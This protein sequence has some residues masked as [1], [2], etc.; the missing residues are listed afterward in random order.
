MAGVQRD[1]KPASHT[2]HV[3]SHTHW[4]REWRYPYQ[5]FRMLLID[6][7]DNLIELM[8]KNPDYRHFLLDSQT[9]PLEDYLEIRPDRRAAL[10]KLVRDGRIHIGPWYC[11]PDTPPIS[12]ESIVRN[13]L[14]G[15]RITEEWGGKKHTGYS[16]FSFGQ[17]AQMPQ[18]YQGFGI[19]HIFFYR[20][21][22][23][24]VTPTEFTWEA[25]DGTQVLG[26]R[27]INPYGRANFYVHVY[28]PVV[29]NKKPFDWTYSW[30][31][32][33]T[34]FHPCDGES[35]RHDYLFLNPRHTK[36][37]H[38]ENLKEA[39]ENIKNDAVRDA[40]TE[41]LLYLDGMDQVNPQP[42]VP[43]IV[44]DANRAG[45]PDRYIHTSFHDY[46]QALKKSVKN[47]P[48][49][50][51]EF[52]HTMREGLWM[53]LFAATLCSRVYLKLANR[54][55]ENRLQQNAEPL[56]VFAQLLG[57]RYRRELLLHA[58][59]ML[60]ANQSHDSIAGCAVD[61]VHEDTEYR[62]RQVTQIAANVAR[63]AMGEV[64]SHIDL[65]AQSDSVIALAVYNPTNHSRTQVLRV[66]V[67]L[68]ESAGARWFGVLDGKREC[69]VQFINDAPFGPIVKSPYD[70]PVPFKARRVEALVEVPDVPPMGYR[71]LVIEPR[72]G[73][74][75]NHG[76]MCPA[77]GVMENEHLRVTVRS[78]GL[79]DILHKPTGAVHTG[80]HNFEDSSEVGDPWTHRQV[81]REEKVYGAGFPV[82]IRR[83]LDGP[84]AAAYEVTCCMRLPEAADDA[85]TE[86][87][88]RTVPFD[89]VSTF[90]LAHGARALAVRTVV[91][92][93]A[94][95]HKLRVLFPTGIAAAKRSFADSHYDTVERDIAV[96]DTSTWKEPAMTVYPHYLY[97]GVQ[98][99][100]RGFAVLARG[101]PEY[102]MI[103]DEP[104]TYALTLLRTY[105][106]PIIGADPEN[107]A[108]DPTQ[109]GGQCLR[110]MAFEYAI[111][112]YG[113]DYRDG[114]LQREAE[115][116]NVPM[117][118]A[119]LGKTQGGN[120]PMALSMLEVTPKQ[121]VLTA[122]KREER[123]GGGVVRIYNPGDT[124]VKGTVRFFRKPKSAA[125]VDL[126]E[127]R[128]RKLAVTGNGATLTVP[129]KKIVT[130]RFGF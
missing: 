96:P 52:R 65:S 70:F 73:P 64:V 124:A 4:D 62:Y 9:V 78:D 30:E 95:D 14:V 128:P 83:V 34:P 90:T 50:R 123:G 94:R 107:V 45:A 100:G 119:Q 91:N 92:N 57:H 41:H 3:V 49:I 20:G 66:F 46:V 61:A 116:F 118:A 58:W 86:R 12:G 120:L 48:V 8:T 32:G 22:N 113:G 54:E 75:V 53:N 82:E 18:I 33:Q 37:Y 121:L 47:L 127:K 117:R 125:E 31:E 60:L 2:M 63:Y 28:R 103:D 6:M 26:M 129:P 115:F 51:G 43:R 17:S 68:P 13:L 38:P 77:P 80:L 105:R 111:M 29:L 42:Q 74:K 99:K 59:K 10:E 88:A 84:L 55:C 79:L 25:P 76:S 101:I 126:N 23:Q 112:P 71:T 72:Q 98:G 87:S 122:V 7:F 11:L 104:R 108:A 21:N 81:R 130:L 69:P 109:S 102:G 67:D 39:L 36:S 97:S 85:C 19:D 24:D 114:E 35:Y 110:T 106:F 1:K 5:E 56:S 93:T 89:V 40:T 15:M 27:A 16:P 44:A